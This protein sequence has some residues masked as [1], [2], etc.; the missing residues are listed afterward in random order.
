MLTCGVD[1]GIHRIYERRKFVRKFRTFEEHVELAKGCACRSDYYRRHP[2]PYDSARRQGFLDALFGERK[3]RVSNPRITEHQITQAIANCR[4]MRE[5]SER[6]RSEYKAASKR[7]MIKSLRC[8]FFPN[9]AYENTKYTKKKLAEMARTVDSRSA[10]EKMNRSAYAA[11]LRMGII[12]E[13]CAHMASLR[14]EWTHDTLQAEAA[15]YSTRSDFAY[16]SR[17]AY[18]FALRRGELGT[19]CGHMHP[20]PK[21]SSRDVFYIIQERNNESVKLTKFG[22]T[23]SRL[24]NQRIEKHS[25]THFTKPVVVAR[26]VTQFARQIE[27]TLLCSFEEPA[28][29]RHCEDGYTELRLLTDFETVCAMNM[30][31]QLANQHSVD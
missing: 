20:S 30:A 28:P 11:A 18:I 17:G 9:D 12:D 14:V 21:Y 25:K 10:F 16:Y 6:F 26:I 4:S 2:G 3:V 5:F 8:K 1:R 29:E 27:K 23:S 15:K 31:A 13:I 24:G 7:K 22:I 19:I